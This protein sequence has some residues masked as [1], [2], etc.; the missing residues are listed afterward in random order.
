MP[1]EAP[2]AENGTAAY[3]REGFL[4]QRQVLSQSRLSPLIEVVARLIEAGRQKRLPVS[5]LDEAQ[6]IPI[7]S[8]AHVL[9]S[10]PFR[11]ALVAEAP[12][13]GNWLHVHIDPLVRS[14]LGQEAVI[15]DATIFFAGGGKA[16]SGGFHRDDPDSIEQG[17]DRSS[18]VA[19]ALRHCSIH[20]PLRP[21]DRFHQLVP[22]THVRP[23]TTEEQGLRC[24]PEET[25][26]GA[27][28]IDL[29][30]GDVL[31]R[32]P[33]ILHRGTNAEGKERCTIIVGYRTRDARNT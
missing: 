11:P 23:L 33:T 1:D 24:K 14:L 26:P 3:V 20:V 17:L 30:P 10:R 12:A 32:H 5:F 31:Y 4:I 2:S 13:I 28:T 21:H 22:R 16:V 9:W 18:L 7:G 29:D 15:L 19:D 27:I 8:L 25:M 6:R